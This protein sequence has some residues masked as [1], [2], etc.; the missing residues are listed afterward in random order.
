LP[1]TPPFIVTPYALPSRY[2]YASYSSFL[3]NWSPIFL[4]EKKLM[5]GTHGKRK[6]AKAHGKRK[7]TK[8]V[9][10]SNKR[11]KQ[12]SQKRLKKLKRNVNKVIKKVVDSALHCDDVISSYV[13]HYTGNIDPTNLVTNCDRVFD[14]FN[15]EA[16]NPGPGSLYPQYSMRFTPFCPTRI[17]DA[18]SVL[19][20]AR[21]AGV[22]VQGGTL[23][24]YKRLNQDVLSMSYKVKFGN[25]TNVPLEFTIYEITNKSNSDTSFLDTA[26]ASIANTTFVASATPQITTAGTTN[27][28]YSQTLSLEY[29]DLDALKKQYTI[30]KHKAKYLMPGTYTSKSFYMGK[31]CVDF[32]KFVNNSQSALSLFPK[33]FKQIVL[34]VRPRMKNF[35]GTNAVPANTFVPGYQIITNDDALGIQV[36]VEERFRLVEPEITV[37]ANAGPKKAFFTS[38][39]FSTPAGF[40][41]QIERFPGD[42]ITEVDL[43]VKA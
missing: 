10:K 36:E 1:P 9:S 30:K 22:D 33:G 42:I 21:A 20:N 38:T 35:F 3:L 13:K 2:A 34:R 18:A 26:Q 19:Y 37:D 39:Q 16:A 24:D 8:S 23:F 5:S 25:Y 40:I 7:R 32:A 28:G 29:S 27:F 6:I 11:K 41:S 4:Y 15:R 43:P 17:L 31:G 14:C 12:P